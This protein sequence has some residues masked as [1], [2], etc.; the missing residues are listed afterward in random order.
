[1]EVKKESE[2]VLN[3]KIKGLKDLFPEIFTEN[4]IDFDKFKSIFKEDISKTNEKY[5]LNWVGKSESIKNIQTNS[6]LTLVPDK[7]G[8]INF[9]ST[10]NIFIEGDNLEVL[11]LLNKSYFGKIKM[12]YIDPPYNTGN[13]IVYNDDFKDSKKAYLE[14]TGQTKDGIKQTTNTKAEGRYHSNWLSMMYPRLFIARNLLKED[15]VIF[16]SIDDNEVHNLRHLMDEIFGEENFISQ[17]VWKKG[18][19][20]NDSAFLSTITEYV[21]IYCKSSELNGFLKKKADIKNYKYLDKDGKRYALTSF[22]RQGINYSS[23][24]DYPIIAPDDTKIYPGGSKEKYE[25]RK[26]GQYNIKD[27][28]WTLSKNEYNNRKEKGLIEFRKIKD[29]YKV[30]YRSYFENKEHP[31]KN[32]IDEVTNSSGDSDLKN[33]FEDKK[34]FLYPKPIKFIKKLLC[35][36]SKSKDNDIILDFFAGSG[37]TAHAVLD[38]NKLDKGNRKFICVQLPEKTPKESISYKDGYTSIADICKERIRRVITKIKSE[39]NSEDIKDLDLG[40]KSFILSN[41]NYSVWNDKLEDIDNLKSQLKLFESSLISNYKDINVIYEILIKEG[42]S[43][44]SNVEK[45]NNLSN[46]VYQISDSSSKLYVCLDNKINKSIIKELNLSKEDI[47]ICLDSA[48]DDSLK[49]NLSKVLES[50]EFKNNLKTI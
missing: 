40:F 42:L 21:L 43:L 30:Y 10:E 26:K 20:K 17:L 13:D 47:F 33:I 7:E 3:N 9:D 46:K 35:F 6:K 50:N 28:C 23:N 29:H 1:M 22:E 4:Q 14:Q 44:N 5:S 37:T 36:I 49:Q 19:G 45:L 31:Y 48:L 12:I 32:F 2:D 15:G 34:Y 41:S 39:Y 27:W 18:G 8:S 24:S 11:K 38:L 16:V 25:L